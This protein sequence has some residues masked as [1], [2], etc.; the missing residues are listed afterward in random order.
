LALIILDTNVISEV[1]SS[2]PEPI[3]V[4]W[5]RRQSSNALYSTSITLAEVLYGLD[6][7][8]PGKRRN[9]LAQLSHT[10][11]EIG[12]RGRI[13]PFDEDAALHYARIRAAKRQTGLAMSPQDAQIAAIAA[14][15]GA[16][17]ATRNVDDFKNC[18]IPIIN[19]WDL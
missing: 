16:S 19:P 7:L 12:L 1:A 10:V 15:A 4:A 11:F 9:R 18:G 2:R 14:T 17:I 5:Y 6:L 8:P 3:V 13:L